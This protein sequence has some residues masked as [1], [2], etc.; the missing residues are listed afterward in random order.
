MLLL[1]HLLKINVQVPVP[2]RKR[3][4]SGRSAS[5]AQHAVGSTSF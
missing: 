5:L 4:K 3:V 1:H 2:D